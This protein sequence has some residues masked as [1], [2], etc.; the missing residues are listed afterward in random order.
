MARFEV[1]W[2]QLESRTAGARPFGIIFREPL[3]GS[4]PGL[5]VDGADLLFYEQFRSAVLTM[6]GVVYTEPQVEDS[7]DVQR[8][9]LDVLAG[10]LP[11]AAVRELRVTDAQDDRLGVHHRFTA[12]V[13][14]EPPAQADGLVAEQVLDY[15]LLQA[16]VAHQTGRL[17]RVGHVEAIADPAVRRHAWARTVAGLLRRG[18]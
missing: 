15:Q 3:G 16:A 5:T 17:V 4:A 2:S 1:R 6:L 8:A 13:S 7:A 18:S 11:P 12:V 9:W 14:G 10:V